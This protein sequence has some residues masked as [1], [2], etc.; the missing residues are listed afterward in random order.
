MLSFLAGFILGVFVLLAYMIKRML[1]S[2]GWDN[3]NITNALRLVSHVVA[4]PE[5]FGKMQYKDG[6][7]PFWYISKDEFS[8]V[9]RTRPPTDS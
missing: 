6:T 4:H 7:K 5:D 1:G 8:E 2:N 9:V 3:S